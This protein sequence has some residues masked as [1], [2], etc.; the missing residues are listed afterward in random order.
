V[1]RHLAEEPPAEV[2]GSA[3]CDAEDEMRDVVFAHIFLLVH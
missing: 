2:L 1:V 3:V